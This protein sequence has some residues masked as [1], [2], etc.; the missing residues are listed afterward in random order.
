MHH[1]LVSRAV[2]IALAALASAAPNPLIGQTAPPE[3]PLS[4]IVEAMFFRRTALGD[5]LP[6]DACS[7]YEQG[8]RPTEFPNGIL[9]GLR[10]LL[11]RPVADPCSVPK[12][13]AG[14]RYERLVRVDSVVPGEPGTVRVHLHVRRGE[15][16]YE[17]VYYLAAGS[18]GQPWSLQEVRTYPPIHTTPPPPR[19]SGREE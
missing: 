11:D 4:A 18:G 14:S 16:T 15:W 6:F 17:E 8:G 2:S 9:P 10:L 12:P 1:Q 13:S 19:A 3:N 5:S 7:V